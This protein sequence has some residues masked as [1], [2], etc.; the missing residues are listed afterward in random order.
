MNKLKR[1]YTLSEKALAANR[2]NLILAR[3]IDPKI[4]YRATP[5]RLKACRANL[6]RALATL[7][8]AS[9]TPDGES[10]YKLRSRKP[11]DENRNSKSETRKSTIEN[12]N[13]KIETP[14]L[15]S[16]SQIQNHKS[17]IF[18]SDSPAYGTRFTRG[19]YA[20]S[21]RRSARLAGEQSHAFD[22]HVQM[23][24]QALAPRNQREVRLARGIA[25]IVWRRLRVFSG[26]ARY[27][28]T[29]LIQCLRQAA[30]GPSPEAWAE[31]LLTP[32]ELAGDL[33]LD[34]VRIFSTEL[35]LPAATDKLNRRLERLS[36]LWVAG[37]GGD[38]GLFQY[39]APVSV[40]DGLL[41]ERSP[42]SMGN[43]FLAPSEVR[44]LMER[45]TACRLHR[46]SP[47]DWGAGPPSTPQRPEDGIG[48][49]DGLDI[50]SLEALHDLCSHS[51][52]AIRH[53]GHTSS[54]VTVPGHISYNIDS[55]D[56]LAE[57]K[58]VSDRQPSIA[59]WSRL[60]LYA[61]AARRETDEVQR[62]LLAKINGQMRDE[63]QGRLGELPQDEALEAGHNGEAAAFLMELILLFTRAQGEMDAARAS[64]DSIGA[65]LHQFLV[66]RFGESAHFNLLKPDYA[67]AVTKAQ[68]E[69]LRC[70]MEQRVAQENSP[71]GQAAAQQRTPAEC[72][73]QAERHLRDV[74]QLDD[75]RLWDDDEETMDDL[76]LEPIMPFSTP[77]PCL[78]RDLEWRMRYYAAASAGM[79]ASFPG[80]APSRAQCRARVGLGRELK[81]KS[82][83]GN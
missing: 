37:R 13:S 60:Q 56:Q 53:N 42:Q 59:I 12:R 3:E 41:A 31:D 15:P 17:Q 67:L 30:R 29:A 8:A 28:R 32:Q 7:R 18:F 77:L 46:F 23:F 1:K 61:E 20:M 6:T 63:L 83:N 25:E 24:R 36:R 47:N 26:H 65:A 78:G 73:A 69:R 48:P 72:V 66:E 5:K 79:L 64:G 54:S 55:K 38:P 80:K 68:Y 50:E 70:A 51:W 44:A 16:K 57:V 71:E 4:R 34:I 22:A 9:L 43:P 14:V 58:P 52:E 19:L 81:Q 76:L 39:M 45:R 27:T 40:R 10:Q 62:L 2:R 49:D 21:L 35:D 33:G 75:L 74:M 11:K 82:R